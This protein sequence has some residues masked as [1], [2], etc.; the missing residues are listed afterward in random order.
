[1]Y[2]L[3]KQVS[4]L[5]LSRKMKELRVIQ[6]ES[7]FYWVESDEFGKA[8]YLLTSIFEVFKLNKNIKKYAAF[9]VAELGVMKSEPILI[10]D[11]Y[12]H[13]CTEA[14]AGIWYCRFLIANTIDTCIRR[15]EA[16]TEA[17]ARAEMGIYLLENKYI[18]AEEVN[19]RLRG[20]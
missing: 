10:N 5:E 4:S 1:M 6:T 14:Y 9:T 2:P 15:I 7:Q 11:K 8:E 19:K 12:Y 13:C 20:E 18:T 3:E 16:D 17:D